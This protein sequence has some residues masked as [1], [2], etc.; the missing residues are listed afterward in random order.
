[1]VQTYTENA[2]ALQYG[3]FHY[4]ANQKSLIDA[5]MLT[6]T[7]KIRKYPILDLDTYK[8]LIQHDIKPRQRLKISFCNLPD[9]EVPSLKLTFV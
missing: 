5:V 1:M 9:I 3:K 4:L 2:R 7:L 8:K 6:Y